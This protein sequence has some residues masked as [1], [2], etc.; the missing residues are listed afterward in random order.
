MKKNERKTVYAICTEKAQLTQLIILNN[1][2]CTGKTWNLNKN[3]NKKLILI[4]L[5]QAT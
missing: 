2:I 4:C 5:I 3:F 1:D